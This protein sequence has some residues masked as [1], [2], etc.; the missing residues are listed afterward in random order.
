MTMT[1]RRRRMTCTT[2]ARTLKTL[3]LIG[4]NTDQYYVPRQKA[5]ARAE[6]P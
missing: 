2:L 5:G 4:G 1:N 6:C 3:D